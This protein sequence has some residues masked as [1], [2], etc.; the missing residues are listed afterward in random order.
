MIEHQLH[1][2][3]MRVVP[4][5]SLLAALLLVLPAWGAIYTD[6]AGLPMQR[7]IERLAA[8]GILRGAGDRFNPT[9]QLTRSELA[10]YLFRAFGLS[11]EGAKLPVYK[12]G[13]DIAP[14]HRSAVAALV[15]MGTVSPQ[16]V[17]LRKGTLLYTLAVD[18]S[19]YSPDQRIVITLTVENTSDQD[20]KFEHA[21]SQLYDFIIRSGKGEEVAKWSLGRPFLP[22]NQPVTLAPKA[23]F[24]WQTL[25]R[26]LDQSD[27]AVEPGRYEIIAIHTTKANPTS[28]SLFFNKGVMSGFS[29]GT[30]R[31]KQP[32]TRLEVATVTAHGL[33]LPDAAANALNVADA[34]AVPQE[35]RG[36]VATALDKR[37]INIV[38][39]REFRPAQAA[40]R[41]ELAQAL[42]AVMEVLKRYNFAKGTLK[43]PVSGN[44][45]QLTIEDEKKSLRTFRIARNHVVYRNDRPADLRDLRPGD[46]LAFLNVGDVGDV[47]Y[48]EATGR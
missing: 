38:G 30:F 1:R 2:L 45:P 34:N 28:L 18:R 32:A 26:Q 21:N 23:K 48:I 41:A 7:A 43:D 25:W 35:L 36:T 33:G 39:A 3:R 24:T 5:V 12:D 37:I 46:T 9:G 29:D 42:D 27:D 17:E 19:V 8:K 13:G 4:A 10:L 14:E 15:S 6:I 20:L 22:L 31:P 16:K 47:A 40:T 44:P 11:G